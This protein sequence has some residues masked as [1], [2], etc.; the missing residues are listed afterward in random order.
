MRS[1]PRRTTCIDIG[2][3]MRISRWLSLRMKPTSWVSTKALFFLVRF[4][5]QLE[6]ELS[7]RND[8]EKQ[9]CNFP[10][11]PQSKES[12]DV[13]HHPGN[14][15]AEEGST[16]KPHKGTV[17]TCSE[18]E[19]L[20]LTELFTVPSWYTLHNHS[21][22]HVSLILIYTAWIQNLCWCA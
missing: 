3:G 2:E 11:R 18:D 9:L 14:E 15:P 16:A 21:L 12:R 19:E 5:E 4:S 1:W 22:V 10:S 8:S 6:V 7:K 17:D 20:L 13:G